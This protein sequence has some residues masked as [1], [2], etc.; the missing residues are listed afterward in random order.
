MNIDAIMKELAQYLRMADEIAA[1]VD[2][3]RDQVKA[4]MSENGLD[5]LIGD[6]HKATYKSVASSRVDTTALRKAYPDIAAQY[7]KQSESMR[8]TFV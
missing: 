4:Y 1:T 3:L 7:T 5:T 8:F 6:E 2:E